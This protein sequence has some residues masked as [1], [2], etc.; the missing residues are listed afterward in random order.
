MSKPRKIRKSRIPKFKSYKEEAGFW[1]THDTEKFADEWE[2]VKVKVA[3]PLKM[4]FSLR[5]DSKTISKMD[6]I[7]EEQ[8]IGPTTLARMWILE[9]LR[10]TESTYSK[11]LTKKKK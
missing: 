10:E 5:L 3:R 6:K 8:G 4:T 11:L 7:A 2:E 1:D 9:K